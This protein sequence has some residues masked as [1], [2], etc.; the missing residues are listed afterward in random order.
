VCSLV[1]SCCTWRQGRKSPSSLPAT[2]CMYPVSAIREVFI[3]VWERVESPVKMLCG[4]DCNLCA[5]PTASSVFC[6]GFNPLHCNVLVRT[7][8]K[9]A[10]HRQRLVR[11]NNSQ[12][13]SIVQTKPTP[14]LLKLLGRQP[15]ET[16]LRSH[17]HEDGQLDGA[18]WQV[19]DGRSCFG[20]LSCTSAKR[21]W[22]VCTC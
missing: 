2:V 15:L 20:R 21:C 18:M 10:R 16:S 12:M 4:H 3:S 1:S 19:Q 7:E 6:P 11:P 9:I 14:R 17:G 22:T 5:P 8:V 13:I